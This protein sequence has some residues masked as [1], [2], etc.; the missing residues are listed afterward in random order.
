M[1][2]RRKNTQDMWEELQRFEGLLDA[3]LRMME[4][5]IQQLFMKIDQM[6]A[7]LFDVQRGWLPQMERYLRAETTNYLQR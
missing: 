3:R 6:G 2:V 7:R 1:H 5:K 4:D